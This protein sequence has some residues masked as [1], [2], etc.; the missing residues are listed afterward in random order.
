MVFAIHFGEIANRKVFRVG[1]L[2][3][4]SHGDRMIIFCKY[5]ES[6]ME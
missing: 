2:G 5:A 6:W 1:K 3:G 4:A